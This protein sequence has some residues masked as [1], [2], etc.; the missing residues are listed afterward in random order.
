VSGNRAQRRAAAAGPTLENRYGKRSQRRALAPAMI[1][2]IVL[3]AGLLLVGQ[4][5]YLLIR[6]GVCILA[7]ITVVFV[8]QSRK[9]AWLVPPLVVAVLW[10]PVLP[11]AFSGQAFRLGHV[12]GAAALLV[13]GASA[14]YTPPRD[15]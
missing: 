5:A 2:A 15:A 7:V 3:L 8:W 11:F 13:T 9:W 10:N 14:R 1:G 6:F 4:E 12:V